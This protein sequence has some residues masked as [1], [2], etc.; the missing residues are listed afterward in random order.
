MCD[1][2]KD[3]LA[4]SV[5]DRHHELEM[6]FAGNRRKYPI[7]EFRLFAQASRRYVERTRNDRMI[8]RDV[9]ELVNGLV[10]YLQ[11]ERKRVPGEVLTE[12]ERLE[13]LLFAGY[14]PHFEGDEPPGL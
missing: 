5:A 12:A 1:A 4:S 7:H 13:C 8:Y 14:D 9:A 6:A 10:D 3:R 11:V 2:E